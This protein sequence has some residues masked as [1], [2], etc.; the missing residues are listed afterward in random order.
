MALTLQRWTGAAWSAEA[1]LVRTTITDSLYLPMQVEATIADPGNTLEGNY[2]NYTRVRIIETFN[3]TT[4]IDD[5]ILFYGKVE[6]VA[7]EF[8]PSYGQVIRIKASDNLNE[9]AKRKVAS[10]YTGNITR[11]ALISSIIS[12]H[13]TTVSGTPNIATNDAQKFVTSLFVEAATVLDNN[14]KNSSVSALRA[15]YDLAKEDPID[16][17]RTGF[18]NVFYLDSYFSG[19]DP[20]PDLHY[21]PRGGRPSGGASARGLTVQYGLAAETNSA[22]AMLPDYE[23]PRAPRELVTRVRV[24]FADTSN[25]VQDREFILINHANP[26]VGGPFTGLDT[27]SWAGPSEAYVELA[28]G[29]PGGN[30][31]LISGRG[32]TTWLNAISGLVISGSSSGTVATVNTTSS[33]PP[34]SLREVIQQDIEATNQNYELKNMAEARALALR[35]LYQGGNTI[36]RGRFKVIRWPWR[37]VTGTA[38]LPASGTVLTDGGGDFLS[39]GIREGDVVVNTSDNVSG[40]I[41][42]VTATTLTTAA[43]MSWDAADGYSVVVFV[44]AGH[45]IRV[46]NA[47]ISGLPA[48]MM[49]T[50]IT[51]DEGPGIAFAEIEAVLNTTTRGEG[52]A[53]NVFDRVGEDLEKAKLRDV[54][55]AADGAAVINEDGITTSR[56][57]VLRPYGTGAKNTGVVR[58][59]E[60]AD[61][62]TDYIGL[63]VLD[64]LAASVDLIL[65][66]G[67]GTVGQLLRTDGT[68]TLTWVGGSAE[69]VMIADGGGVAI[70]TGVVGYLRIP[71][72]CTIIA[73][74]LL[75]DQST[76]TTV[77]IWKDTYANYPPVDADSIT[78]A[79]PLA[80]AAANK[81]EN[82]TLTGWTTSIV[83]GDILGFN[84]DANNNAQKLTITLA[85]RLT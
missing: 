78:A 24:E 50:K 7:P 35:I 8:D 44:R 79:A 26:T 73:G 72:A 65:P 45:L 32:N 64:S 28:G 56:P 53:P 37:T 40:T 38:G 82:T 30:W 16:A 76:T 43:G 46:V 9:L 54:L 6:H 61:N 77:D 22:R 85:V 70:A 3:T 39:Y 19:N 34:G 17:N 69:I 25:V 1:N 66:S 42:G 57:L 31:L 33:T 36:T 60:L 67:A 47:N 5:R 12:G 62:G 48:D 23:F 14:Y 20:I 4:T 59:R 81:S 58:M 13:A 29:I 63:K 11:S 27:L 10:S 15:I 2:S 21:F 80:T 55:V 68:D 84:I 71:V 74:R 83:A 49:V 51:Y 41:A 75:A 52:P 18:G